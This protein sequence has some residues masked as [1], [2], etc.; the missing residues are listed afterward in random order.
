M[1]DLTKKIKIRKDF[2]DNV[3]NKITIDDIMRGDMEFSEEELAELEGMYDE[4]DE[5]ADRTIDIGDL[6]SVVDEFGFRESVNIE[7]IREG[8][9]SI[10]DFKEKLFKDIV[11]EKLV[12]R[13]DS[14][15]EIL[16]KELLFSFPYFFYMIYMSI[17]N[18]NKDDLGQFLRSNIV[19][20]TIFVVIASILHFSGFDIIFKFNQ[21]LIVSLGLIGISSLME[22]QLKNKVQQGSYIQEETDDTEEGIEAEEGYQEGFE[23]NYGE[24]YGEEYEEDYEEEY[25]EEI[26]PSI[27]MKQYLENFPLKENV[28]QTNIS[29][30]QLE[31]RL[32]KCLEM[33][34]RKRLTCDYSDRRSIFESME[35]YI[36]CNNPGFSELRNIPKNST[37]YNN[38]CFLI[39]DGLRSIYNELRYDGT[40]TMKVISLAENKL[41]YKL[42]VKLP[43]E[44][45]I[46]KVNSDIKYIENKFKKDESDNDVSIKASSYSD[47]LI[48][49]VMKDSKVPVTIGDVIRYYDEK[50]DYSLYEDFFSDEYGLPI[51]AGLQNEEKPFILDLADSS[52]T[53]MAVAGT[54]G[55]GKSWVIFS[56]MFNL[57][58]QSHPGDVSFILFDQKNDTQIN[59]LAEFPHVLGKFSGDSINNF[60]DIMKEINLELERRKAICNSFNVSKWADLRKLFAKDVEN[61]H[62]FPWLFIIIDETPAILSD[63]R[64]LSTKKHDLEKEFIMIISSIS[65]QARAYGMKI[66]LTAQRG[67]NQDL[68]RDVMTQCSIMYALKMNE[69]DL[70]TIG[71]ADKGVLSAER[72]GV[73]VFKKA[74]LTNKIN[75]KCLGIGGVED[76]QILHITKI[77]ALE[78]HLRIDEDEYYYNFQGMRLTDNREER[79]NRVLENYKIGKIFPED[80]SEKS[81]KEI[82]DVLGEST[83]RVFG[84]EQVRKQKEVEPVVEKPLVVAGKKEE[85]TYVPPVVDKNDWQEKGKIEDIDEEGRIV[86]VTEMESVNK[87]KREKINKEIEISDEQKRKNLKNELL[88]KKIS[89]NNNLLNKESDVTKEK[90]T[91]EIEEQVMSVTRDL[92]VRSDRRIDKFIKQNYTNGRV[93]KSELKEVF[94]KEEIDDALSDLLIVEHDGYYIA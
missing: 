85:D 92:T 8:N 31:A 9:V 1:I 34:E 39:Y 49:R 43:S 69:R 10:E 79:R 32:S 51:I 91:K 37:I 56:F 70:E 30:R 21:L 71:M 74:T 64:T 72:T 45:K 73:A 17:K 78:W 58:L 42:E 60:I 59:A 23:E 13:D 90:S 41:F 28:L 61:R 44:I 67:V 88:R 86:G 35:E 63:L 36:F 48:F 20:S 3:L 75:M 53:N 22:I 29:K 14:K 4:E 11:Q 81:S 25:E 26:E 2:F 40:T 46:N 52:E 66:I 47:Y 93:K 16:F 65:K 33:S 38:I 83:K 94:T 84:I 62:K 80:P 12:Q 68:P 82:D 76:T 57:I 6:K 7:N 18:R 50:D 55:S 77:A 87:E 24:D 5:F 54:T 15:Y 19:V 27:N 89:I